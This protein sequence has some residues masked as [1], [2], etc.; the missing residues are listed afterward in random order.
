MA[1]APHHIRA[2]FFFFNKS[3]YA[4]ISNF[5]ENLNKAIEAKNVKISTKNW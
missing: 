2:K 5:F 1:G 4:A 3:R